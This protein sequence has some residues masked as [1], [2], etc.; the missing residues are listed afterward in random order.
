[1]GVPNGGSWVPNGDAS[2]LTMVTPVKLRHFGQLALDAWQRNI[3]GDVLEAGV[4]RGGASIYLAALMRAYSG[5]AS[6]RKIVLADA[7]QS[8]PTSLSSAS[9]GKWASLSFHHLAY[10]DM[11]S[12]FK[13]FGLWGDQVE[14]VVGYFSASL[15]VFREQALSQGRR[16]S[17]LRIDADM[18][19]SYMDVLYNLYDLLSVGGFL[20]CDDCIAIKES[21]RALLGFHQHHMIVDARHLIPES[22]RDGSF[23]Y[24][25]SEVVVDVETYRE[26]HLARQRIMSLNTSR[27]TRILYKPAV[28]AERLALARLEAFPVRSSQELGRLCEL[29]DPSRSLVLL[30]VAPLSMKP[31][32]LSKHELRWTMKLA[33]AVR[34]DWRQCA[35]VAAIDSAASFDGNL[36]D[37]LAQWRIRTWIGHSGSTLG[38]G[39][40][41]GAQSTDSRGMLSE[42]F[43]QHVSIEHLHT[44]LG[45]NGFIRSWLAHSCSH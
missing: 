42:V 4:W 45:L 34:P 37:A 38:I 3:S 5:L 1:M 22:E 40:M 6:Q 27:H 13:N 21:D 2:A 12:I 25:S 7:F 41:C 23:W 16:L 35:F 32:L 10:D 15:S 17:V 11:Q 9:G 43:E 29:P 20:I 18:Y 19:E 28:I 31:G 8:M 26:W 39:I 14:F 33:E 44:E 24:K 36:E 30:L